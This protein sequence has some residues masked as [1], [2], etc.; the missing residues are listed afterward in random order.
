MNLRKSS[1]PIGAQGCA[2][3]AGR[4]KDPCTFQ[5]ACARTVGSGGDRAADG[6]VV[7]PRIPP[8]RPV[9]SMRDYGTLVSG[10]D[11]R[12]AVKQVV[13]RTKDPLL[14][15]PPRIWWRDQE[16]D[17]RCGG[18]HL[19]VIDGAEELERTKGFPSFRVR[20]R[21]TRVLLAP[22]R[23]RLRLEATG[24]RNQVSTAQFKHFWPLLSGRYH[25]RSVC[26]LVG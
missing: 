7:G 21:R 15:R 4:L 23:L 25:C 24:W 8:P 5:H 26:E 9:A 19:Q 17:G 20:K 14:M 16:A 12:I 13:S 18:D 2:L 6:N 22:A 1:L 11:F 10:R 3:R